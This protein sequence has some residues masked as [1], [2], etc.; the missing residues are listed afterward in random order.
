MGQVDELTQD[1]PCASTLM[2]T[3]HIAPMRNLHHNQQ[4]LKDGALDNPNSYAEIK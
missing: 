4:I 3:D 2:V 1:W